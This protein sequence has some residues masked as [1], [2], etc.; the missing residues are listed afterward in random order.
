M[1]IV[2]AKVVGTA[3][4][5]LWLTEYPD[6]YNNIFRAALPEADFHTKVLAGLSCDVLWASG[7]AEDLL[8]KVKDKVLQRSITGEVFLF[9]HEGLNVS[10]AQN[11]PRVSVFQFAAGK[12][13]GE[14]CKLSA[15]A[16]AIGSAKTLGIQDVF[17]FF[18]FLVPREEQELSFACSVLDQTTGMSPSGKDVSIAPNKMRAAIERRLKS[19]PPVKSVKRKNSSKVIIFSDSQL[20]RKTLELYY[21]VVYPGSARESSPIPKNV[22]EFDRH[23]PTGQCI[24][25]LVRIVVD[26]S[27][28][29]NN[30]FASSFVFWLWKVHL[31]FI[32]DPLASRPC[33]ILSANLLEKTNTLGALFRETLSEW[34]IRCFNDLQNTVG[35]AISSTRDIDVSGPGLRSKGIA[36][37]DAI[38][39]KY[40]RFLERFLLAVDFKHICVSHELN[41]WKSDSSKLPGLVAR[42]IA[43]SDRLSELVKS[44]LSALAREHCAWL[45]ENKNPLKKASAVWQGLSDNAAVARM[46]SGALK[47]RLYA[48]AKGKTAAGIDLNDSSPDHAIVMGVLGEYWAKGTVDYKTVET[49]IRKAA[50]V[51]KPGDSLERKLAV[52]ISYG[53]QQLRNIGRADDISCFEPIY[54]IVKETKKWPASYAAAEEYFKFGQLQRVSIDPVKI[55]DTPSLQ[56]PDDSDSNPEDAFMKKE[57][58]REDMNN[59]VRTAANTSFAADIAPLLSDSQLSVYKQIGTSEHKILS[60]ML[61]FANKHREGPSLAGKTVLIVEDDIKTAKDIKKVIENSGGVGETAYTFDEAVKKLMSPAAAFAVAI[62]DVQIPKNIRVELGG[63]PNDTLFFDNKNQYWGEILS[64]EM[65]CLRLPHIIL[66]STLPAWTKNPAGRLSREKGLEHALQHID[67][68]TFFQAGSAELQKALMSL[69]VDRKPFYNSCEISLRCSLGYSVDQCFVRLGRDVANLNFSDP[70]V[71]LWKGLVDAGEVDVLAASKKKLTTKSAAAWAT[72]LM[73]EIA[74]VLGYAEEYAAAPDAQVFMEKHF[75]FSIDCKGM[76]LR[77]NKATKSIAGYEE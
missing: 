6:P 70:R 9:Y 36:V 40:E 13:Y 21:S 76:K 3:D 11:L 55:D 33:F 77:L 53:V 4:K 27:D 20:I 14:K 54:N 15:I 44:E 25:P 30:A 2:V 28:E 50:K 7:K 61:S 63:N 60:A 72:P 39:A 66:S 1:H 22:E 56:I 59:K 67:K 42:T 58:D 37:K 57:S 45:I 12:I 73:E 41:L 19:C 48:A 52:L 10:W 34:D 64:Q 71:Q 38:F 5:D 43:E 47:S 32:K 35:G 16:P 26:G 17:A 74:R 29:C 46:L 62:V 8:Q 31:A 75:D 51:G 24:S 49:E 69:G 18:R 65:H 68:T 23:F